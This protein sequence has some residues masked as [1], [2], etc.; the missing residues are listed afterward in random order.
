MFAL[1]PHLENKWTFKIYM[2]EENF[3]T[4]CLCVANVIT[5]CLNQHYYFSDVE[6]LLRLKPL[7]DDK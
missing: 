2:A 4:I 7:S 1:E 6:N 5:H 3:Y